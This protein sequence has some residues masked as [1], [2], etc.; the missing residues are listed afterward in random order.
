MPDPIPFHRPYYGRAAPERIA[1]ALAAE[2]LHGGGTVARA[3]EER[4][5]R[6]LGAAC[7]M[8]TPS[9]TSA[10]EIAAEAAGLGPGDEVIVPG[11][12]FLSSAAAIARTGARPV[13]VDVDP[14]DICLD[15][16]QVRAAITPRTRAIVAVHYAGQACDLA[17]LMALAK[18]HDLIVIE[19]AAQGF[20]C[21]QGGRK[22]GTIG[23]FG[24]FS[25]HDSKVFTTGEGGALVVNDP[26]FIDR[27]TRIREKGSNWREFLAGKVDRYGWVAQGTSG[28]LSGLAAAL[29]DAQFDEADAII[30]RRQALHRRYV[31]ALAG[32]LKARGWRMLAERP[33]ERLTHHIL[34]IVCDAPQAQRDL[35]AHLAGLG[36]QALAHYPSLHLA[37]YV[38]ERGWQPSSNLPVTE[39]V[40]GSLIR[41]PVSTLM[42]DIDIDRVTVAVRGYLEQN[43]PRSSQTTC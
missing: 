22:L 33:G 13:F 14:A 11:Y 7:V 9:C 39:H 19:D 28:Y 17:Q 4:L 16:D 34:W 20:L 1:T 10:L 40:A 27:A 41:L 35:A 3:I 12:T 37:P 43:Q 26:S 15:L 18:A 24:C 36:I 8:L 6:L 42:T 25:F 38:L 21:E 31:L 23:H 2:L 5:S 32:P 30:A 29:L